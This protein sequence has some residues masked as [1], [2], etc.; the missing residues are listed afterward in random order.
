MIE[1]YDIDMLTA[2]YM[3][4]TMFE[5]ALWRLLMEAFYKDQ[6]RIK[7]G[8]NSSCDNDSVFMLRE[9]DN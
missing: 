5:P 6:E 9:F 7:F 8:L 4:G 3:F 1:K 2:R